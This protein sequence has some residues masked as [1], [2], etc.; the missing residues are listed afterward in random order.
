MILPTYLTDV[1]LAADDWVQKLTV[2]IFCQ[3]NV[4]L[5]ELDNDSAKGIN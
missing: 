3:C 5:Q 2:K 4:I 1:V